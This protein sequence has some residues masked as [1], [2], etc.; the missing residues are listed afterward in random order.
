[1]PNERHARRL[2]I[3]LTVV[4]VA[5]IVA[6][7]AI[8]YAVT[9]SINNLSPGSTVYVYGNVSSRFAVGSVSVFELTQG[10]QSVAVMWNG[11]IPSV[12]SHVL[13]HGYVMGSSGLLL[14]FRYIRASSVTVW[15]F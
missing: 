4:V 2:L 14:H 13:V 9:T 8:P 15:Y 12:G 3:A 5:S 10:N 7:G 1:M 11:T 6:Y